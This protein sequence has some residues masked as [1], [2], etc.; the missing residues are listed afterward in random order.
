M[1]NIGSTGVSSD[2]REPFGVG[3][4]HA[5][6]F[7]LIGGFRVSQIIRAA[8]LYSLPEHLA[9]G[10][11]T[12]ES[13]AVAESLNVEATFR[14]MRACAALKL[15]TYDGQSK[16]ATTSL[17]NTLRKDNP[18]SMRGLALVQ[19]S[20]SHW[21][22]WGH[23]SEAI[24]TGEPQ[25]VATLGRSAWEYVADSPADVAAF[26]D[27]MKS[28]SLTFNRDAASLV[29]TKSVK[30]AVDVGGGSGTFIHA[31]MAVNPALRG[32]VFDLPAAI[33]V[34]VQTGQELGLQDCFSVVAGDFFKDALPR[35]DLYLLKMILHD[36]ND[37]ACLAILKNCRR[38][39]NP[40]GR[41]VV[42]DALIGEVGTPGLAPL[43]DLTMMVVLGGKERSL[44][45]FQALFNA[46][47]FR[48]TG[49]TPTSTPFVLIEAMAE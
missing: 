41:I 1:G 18:A 2:A 12:A 38:A 35:A 34:A 16:F 28:I 49:M 48:F 39:I 29:D 14:F 37:D 9:Q 47:G 19:A 23:F 45:E 32:T 27:A 3:N 33:P 31:L 25:A 20:A 11:A 40:G 26:A 13:I 7:R 4:D 21:L 22:P 10:A 5:E 46:T 24:K 44:G 15:L 43:M 8:A 42:A 17:L 6:M 36:W 30:V